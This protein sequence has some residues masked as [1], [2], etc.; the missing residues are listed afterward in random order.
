MLVLQIHWCNTSKNDDTFLSL[1]KFCQSQ[2]VN[3][4]LCSVLLSRTCG[5]ARVALRYK[6]PDNITVFIYPT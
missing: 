2:L 6:T 1:T 3:Y 4:K 5:I